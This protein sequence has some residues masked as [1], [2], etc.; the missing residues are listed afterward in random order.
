LNG[1]ETITGFDPRARTSACHIFQLLISG[2]QI[3]MATLSRVE[4][5]A[6]GYAF[7]KA[8]SNGLSDVDVT[9]AVRVMGN[10]RRDVET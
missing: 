7:N 4:L 2:K 9:L 10:V 5:T 6:L 3:S 1:I 8:I